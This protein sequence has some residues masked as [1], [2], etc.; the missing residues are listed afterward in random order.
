MKKDKGPSKE[1]FYETILRLKKE[2]A[3]R[4]EG[5]YL[6]YLRDQGIRGKPRRVKQGEDKFFRKY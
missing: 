4:K 3:I 1:E 6:G 2:R 5:I